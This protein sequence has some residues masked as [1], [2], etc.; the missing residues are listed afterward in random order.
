MLKVNQEPLCRILPPRLIKCYCLKRVSESSLATS[1][2]SLP[3]PRPSIAKSASPPRLA[4]AAV[5]GAR[6][7]RMV[8][9]TSCKSQ[10]LTNL[11]HTNITLL[12]F[13]FSHTVSSLI[14]L[15]S[16]CHWLGN[17]Y[18]NNNEKGVVGCWL[19]PDYHKVEIA[20]VKCVQWETYALQFGMKCVLRDKWHFFFWI[21]FEF[22][23]WFIF[24]YI[25][26]LLSRTHFKSD[27]SLEGVAALSHEDFRMALKGHHVP[28]LYPT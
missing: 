1:L 17:K 26:F 4:E 20:L 22:I 7:W 9:Q 21:L 5:V 10:Q 16:F 12:P 3:S 15:P 24:S 19:A 18:M 11:C 6:D 13:S 23:N 14:H 8:P 28:F 2:P 27:I 25:H